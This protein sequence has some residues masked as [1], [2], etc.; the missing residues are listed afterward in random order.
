[1]GVKI[2]FSAVHYTALEMT[3]KSVEITKK[4]IDVSNKSKCRFKFVLNILLLCAPF[5]VSGQWLL[6]LL[7]R[8]SDL[9]S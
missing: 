4:F 9:S 5:F 6:F 7:L 3:L 2:R 1:M 8:C